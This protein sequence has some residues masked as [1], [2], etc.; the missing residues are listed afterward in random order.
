MGGQSKR[1]N[2]KGIKMSEC[3]LKSILLDDKSK[4]EYIVY[5]AELIKENK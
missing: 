4:F 1:I 3:D 5:K 2:L